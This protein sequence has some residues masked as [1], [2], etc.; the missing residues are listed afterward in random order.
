MT[1]LPIR[2]PEAL[3]ALMLVNLA[4]ALVFAHSWKLGLGIAAIPLLVVAVGAIGRSDRAVLAFAVPLLATT[5]PA[6]DS[7]FTIGGGIVAYPSDVVIA[8]V[9]L[10]WAVARLREGPGVVRPRASPVLGLPFVVFGV[11]AAYAAWRGHDRYG[12][13]LIGQPARLV[14]YAAIGLALVDVPA[15]KLYR[16]L[17]AVFY[18][19]TVWTT[20][21]G[22]YLL[23]TGGSQTGA[24]ELSTGGTRVLSL[25]VSLYLASTLFL[26]LLNLGRARTAG[27]AAGHAAMAAIA[28]LGIVLAFGRGTFVALAV[29]LPLLLVGLRRVRSSIL[30]LVPLLVPVIVLGVLTVARASPQIGPTLGQ[31]LSLSSFSGA[32]DAS[33]RWREAANHAVWQQVDESPWTGVGFGRRASFELD[34]TEFAIT[35]DPHNSFMWLMAGGGITLLA[36]FGVMVLVFAADAVRRYRRTQ[37]PIERALIVWASLS[38][39][40]FLLN[41]LTG[42]LL[43]DATLL[44][45]VWLFLLVPSVAARR[46]RT[47]ER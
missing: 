26:A 44:L 2:R 9:L 3:A 38:L 15:R 13:S 36:S 45:A 29:T 7:S 31:R 17:V 28:T 42:P 32:N 30:R 34:G 14:A 1:G 20:L 37:R 18:V 35:Q 4:G 16:G 11:L 39:V 46:L 40:T 6:L 41:A 33:V 10:S 27:R 19:G 21:D 47:A 22:L 43:S 24:F 23:A 25:S 8:L 12:A 5:V